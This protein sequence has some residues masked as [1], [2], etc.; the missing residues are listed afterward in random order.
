MQ[1]KLRTALSLSRQ[2]WQRYLQAWFL[3][4]FIDL[5]LRMLPFRRLQSWLKTRPARPA[6]PF[7][8]TESMIRLT[9]SAVD[10]AI[11]NHLYPMTCLRRALTLQRMLARR[12][13]DSELRFG[14]QRQ[15]ESITAHAWLEHNGQ[16]LGETQAVEKRYAPLAFQETA[17]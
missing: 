5:G 2:D 14:V 3:L 13:V 11:R 17:R 6:P 4:L 10:R 7:N 16:P 8:E 1:H 12:G 15:G 9:Q